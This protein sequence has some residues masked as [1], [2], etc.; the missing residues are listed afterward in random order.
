MLENKCNIACG[1]EYAGDDD[2]CITHKTQ[3]YYLKKLLP[4]ECL[5]KEFDLLHGDCGGY[6][7]AD[8]YYY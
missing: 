5:V 2:K 7:P 3:N 4:S 8:I 6:L 1:K